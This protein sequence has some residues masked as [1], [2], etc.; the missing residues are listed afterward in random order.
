MWIELMTTRTLFSK[1]KKS[2]N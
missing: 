1:T 2:K